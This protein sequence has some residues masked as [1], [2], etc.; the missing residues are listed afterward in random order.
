MLWTEQS[1]SENLG[2]VVSPSELQWSDDVC[3]SNKNEKIA[4]QITQYKKPNE[5]TNLSSFLFHY[6]FDSR[7]TPEK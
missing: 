1:C 5:R 3:H 2:A 6:D 7:M 4:T